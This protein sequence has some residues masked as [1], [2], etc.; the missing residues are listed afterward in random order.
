MKR[1]SA[2]A[3]QSWRSRKKLRRAAQYSGIARTVYRADVEAAWQRRAA[4]R[5]Q[6]PDLFTQ[7]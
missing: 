7:T 6:Q 1:L 3:L 5:S 2:A 4:I